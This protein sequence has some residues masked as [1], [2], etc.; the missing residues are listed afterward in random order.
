MPSSPV[1][2]SVSLCNEFRLRFSYVMYFVLSCFSLALV[3]SL[4]VCS[5]HPFRA[6]CRPV[7]MY[8][9]RDI[10]CIVIV[11]Y[12]ALISVLLVSCV[13]SIQSR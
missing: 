5:K 9:D 4:L 7:N 3:L 11:T 12:Y 13:V 2:A 10:S 6:M 1:G 8:C